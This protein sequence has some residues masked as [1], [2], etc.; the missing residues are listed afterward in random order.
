MRYIAPMLPEAR[1][2]GYVYHTSK[3]ELVLQAGGGPAGAGGGKTEKAT[4][5]L[6]ASKKL[7]GVDLRGTSADVVLM[8]GPHEDVESQAAAQVRVELGKSG[9]LAAVTVEGAS[10]SIEA[11]GKSA[12]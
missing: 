9:E 11:P 10:R 4:L 8:L 12:Y 5:L 7:V 6:S 2:T 3:D 1:A